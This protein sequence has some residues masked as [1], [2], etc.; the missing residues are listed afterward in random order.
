MLKVNVRH[1]LLKT[2][3]IELRFA[4]EATIEEVKNKL[5]RNTGTPP[6][7]QELVL[8]K[9]DQKI[10]LSPEQATL[11]DFNVQDYDEISLNDKNPHA[12]FGAAFRKAEKEYVPPVADELKYMQLENSVYRQIQWKLKN[13]KAFRDNY[14]TKIRERQ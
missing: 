5:Y 9:G 8:I 14:F 1:S 7:W 11:A 4:P 12:L 6:E 13:D 3:F 2:N 10:V